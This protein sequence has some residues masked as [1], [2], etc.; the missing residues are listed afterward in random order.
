MA[1]W[2]Q[3][4]GYSVMHEHDPRWTAVDE[5][6]NG[7]LLAPSRNPYHEALEFTRS[8]SRAKGLPDIAVFA[9]QG[10][11]M[12][13]QIQITGAK[14]VLEVG[15]L[16]GYSAIWMAAGTGAD[17]KVTTV[18]VNPETKKIAEENI[19][20]AGL[21]DR[22][23]VLLGPGVEVLPALLEEVKAGKRPPFDFVFIDADKE[24]N[25]A[26]F[27]CALQMVK[28]RTCIIVDNVVRRGQL[29]DPAMKDDSRIAGTRRL[30]EAVGKDDRV[31]AVV[32][33]TVAEKNYDG[34]MMAL[35]K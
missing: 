34:F 7:H 19:A 23:T 10:K 21:S 8:N 33:Q 17:G 26:Y 30:I 28:P 14:N 22:V 6:A 5:Y 18:E 9:A 27:E 29:A 3:P 24:N 13:M 31:E 25:L 2:N 11:F 15:T 16:G 32:I 35:V 4:G 1:S 20:H 12:S